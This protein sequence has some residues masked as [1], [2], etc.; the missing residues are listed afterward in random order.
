MPGVV[1]TR[2]GYTGGAHRDPTYHDMGDH[3]EAFEVTFDTSA[4][5]Y[6]A[7]LDAFWRSHDPTRRAYSRQYKA[8]IYHAGE[9]QRRLAL[10]SRDRE[11][12]QR[13]RE[14]HTEVAPLARFYAAEAYHQKYRL[15][16]EGGLLRELERLYPREEDLLASTAA[17][18][19]NGYLGGHGD[20]AALA[21]ELRALGLS[22]EA[23]SRVERCVIG[24]RR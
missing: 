14:I 20:V 17:S 16:R 19:L 13:G 22:A 15:R 21:G 18:R 24:S 23:A 10:E 9:E 3:A 8:A 7:L 4:T 1:S 11:A 6:G 5:S 12:T 2:V